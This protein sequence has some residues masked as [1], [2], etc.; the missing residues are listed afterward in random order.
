M[1]EYEKAHELIE[2]IKRQRLEVANRSKVIEKL[3]LELAATVHAARLPEGVAGI[4]SK[5]SGTSAGWAGEARPPKAKV[6]A[7]SAKKIPPSQ[8]ASKKSAKSSQSAK[9][10]STTNGQKVGGSV[11][12]PPTLGDLVREVIFEANRP[13]KRLEIQEGLQKRN[14]TNSSKD[15]FRTLGVRLHNLK[16]S[17]VTGVGDGKFDLT[18]AWKKKLA[19]QAEALAKKQANAVP[20]TA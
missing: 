16:S 2:Q 6:V 14:Y 19:R 4:S 18:P 20:A 11:N 12:K 8:G 1:N 9:R 7:P 15:P 3:E 13:L 10:L 5:G 17:G